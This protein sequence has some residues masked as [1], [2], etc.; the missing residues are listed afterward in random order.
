MA[1][2][3]DIEGKANRALDR[4]ENYERMR[5]QQRR[6][7]R[8]RI[9]LYASASRRLMALLVDVMIV[10]V[11]LGTV[12][13]FID[14]LVAPL[15]VVEVAQFVNDGWH[16]IRQG[17]YSPEMFAG[18]FLRRGYVQQF[19]LSQFIQVALLGVMVVPM[20]WRWQ[21]TLGMRLVGVR[22]YAADR[23][24]KPGLFACLMFFMWGTLTLMTGYLIIPFTRERRALHDLLSGTAVV[25]RKEVRARDAAQALLDADASAEAEIIAQAE[26]RI[27]ARNA[28][29]DQ[30]G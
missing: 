4:V 5:K 1:W 27:V 30:D 7:R 17:R 13:G 2:Y 3:D 12:L 19:L 9:A 28:E 22:L 20:L 25:R 11:L 10:Y 29:Q 18:E 26:A 8:R 16:G 21:A 24:T 15:N 23:F 14:R 6:E